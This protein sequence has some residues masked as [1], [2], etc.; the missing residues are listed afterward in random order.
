MFKERLA[1]IEEEQ[2]GWGKKRKKGFGKAK[3]S[4]TGQANE[5]ELDGAMKR[6]QLLAASKEQL[7]STSTDDHRVNS[8]SN[9]S[10]SG[11]KRNA[12]NVG[13]NLLD[14][15]GFE[16]GSGSNKSHKRW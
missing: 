6:E 10:S 12:G 16:N 11:W 13:L 4:E 3:K 5:I 1:K 7:S 9:P 2:Q 15:G 14:Q 8:Q